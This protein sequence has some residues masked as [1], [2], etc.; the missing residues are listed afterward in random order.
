MQ[1]G[2]EGVQKYTK[3]GWTPAAAEPILH[4]M[5]SPSNPSTAPIAA[6]PSQPSW[7]AWLLPN[8]HGVARYILACFSLL[9][10]PI[11]L[12]PA[13]RFSPTAYLV[14]F[15]LLCMCMYPFC[16]YSG[17]RHPLNWLHLLTG[18]LMIIPQM[19]LIGITCL[20]LSTLAGR[21]AWTFIAFQMIYI[22]FSI[23]AAWHLA[24][25]LEMRPPRGG[26]WRTIAAG[27]WTLKFHI[28][29][30]LLNVQHLLH[31]DTIEGRR[32]FLLLSQWA[33]AIYILGFLWI[34]WMTCR[35]WPFRRR[36]LLAPAASLLWLLPLCLIQALA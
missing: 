5:N 36:L 14:F 25:S 15:M 23:T 31:F 6:D 3:T 32:E 34:I 27:L 18:P 26:F 13:A 33:A 1:W 11:L 10:L 22:V 4:P 28:L 17:S 24:L 20:L 2:G 29:L 8:K 16:M 21:G 19:L 12:L 30:F 35:Q 7:A 9:P